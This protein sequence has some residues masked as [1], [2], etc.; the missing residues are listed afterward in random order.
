M[1][2]NNFNA[3]Q[4][5]CWS[6]NVFFFSVC[7][8]GGRGRPFNICLFYFTPLFFF[9]GIGE[10]AAISVYVVT[11]AS[12]EPVSTRTCEVRRQCAM[13]FF[14]L[15]FL[16]LSGEC[17]VDTHAWAAA[18]PCCG[19][20]VASTTCSVMACTGCAA[21]SQSGG[22]VAPPARSEVAVPDTAEF[23]YA[24]LGE[25]GPQQTTIAELDAERRWELHNALQGTRCRAFTTNTAS[26]AG[27]SIARPRTCAKKRKL[28]TQLP[29]RLTAR[30]I[31]KG[32]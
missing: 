30:L 7:T 12:T 20:G 10:S 13:A 14:N 8:S 4:S 32:T 24:S 1:R 25:K 17:W 28:A 31:H 29:Q 11:S 15:F 21:S 22:V 2:T 16:D 9:F 3:H 18:S 23:A 19:Q 5:H 27:R 6:I 26:G